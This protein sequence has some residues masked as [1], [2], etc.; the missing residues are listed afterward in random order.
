VT[1]GTYDHTFDT[2]DP[3][4]YRAGFL[5]ASGGTAAGAEAV[6]ANC[7][8]AG[9]AY[10]NVH[11][12]AFP[13]GEIRGFLVAPQSAKAACKD[14]GFQTLPDPRTGQSFRNQ[15]HCVSFMERQ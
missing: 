4:T 9:K 6:L 1:S 11:T 10:L 2:L 5:S 15:G 7:L 3:A 14:A 8:A 13:S 12:T